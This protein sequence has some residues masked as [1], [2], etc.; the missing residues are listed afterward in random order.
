MSMAQ[1][2]RALASRL[3]TAC[4]S[5]EAWPVR[6][7]IRHE[8]DL[9]H[10]ELQASS[11]LF[12][13]NVS[14]FPGS[15]SLG[16]SSSQRSSSF[17]FSP[18]PGLH[19]SPSVILSTRSFFQ[20][21]MRR[22]SRSIDEE[23][24]SGLSIDVNVLSTP[25]GATDKSREVSP[26]SI[27]PPR[28]SSIQSNSSSISSLSVGG[29]DKMRRTISGFETFIETAKT[30]IKQG[31]YLRVKLQHAQRTALEAYTA[32]LENL[33]DPKGI[34]SHTGSTAFASNEDVQQESDIGSVRRFHLLSTTGRHQGSTRNERGP[35]ER[36]A[37]TG[38]GHALYW[39]KMSRIADSVTW[40]LRLLIGQADQLTN[41][42]TELN[43]WLRQAR[44][45]GSATGLLIT[46]SKEVTNDICDKLDS[47]SSLSDTVQEPTKDDSVASS[48][49]SASLSH[50]A[51]DSSIR[52]SG[53]PNYHATGV[54]SNPGNSQS[55]GSSTP[56]KPSD[57]VLTQTKP[58]R[59]LI[60]CLKS[61]QAI[62][63]PKTVASTT[64]GVSTEHNFQTNP[65]P[66]NS[67]SDVPRFPSRLRRISDR[68]S[69]KST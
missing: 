15:S 7:R 33:K 44:E 59:Q 52:Q 62:N 43:S 11:P 39:R 29:F 25:A 50:C 23:T 46:S 8:D 14:V 2:I 20:R 34:S 45:A 41:T 35:E 31:P 6:M 55:T 68:S 18:S 16:D 17:R 37:S 51:Y 56:T 21:R 47:T 24:S 26:L 40:N 38:S 64:H 1:C 67:N 4:G 13:S 60:S 12:G 66:S 48:N 42:L 53:L 5:P 9:P 69:T 49:A 27:P 65:T 30:V 3:N 28:R 32:F 57:S 54:K 19:R 63:P 36:R 10:L 22:D 61:S 58:S